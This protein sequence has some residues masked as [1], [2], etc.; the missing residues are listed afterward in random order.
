MGEEHL[1]QT[2]L[3]RDGKAAQEK[4][5]TTQRDGFYTLR[6]VFRTVADE[7]K[8]QPVVDS[9]MGHESGH[10]STVCRETIADERYTFDDGCA[11]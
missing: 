2:C 8:D 4:R 5:Y 11:V 3:S 9:I 10:M 1:P 6:H 7:T